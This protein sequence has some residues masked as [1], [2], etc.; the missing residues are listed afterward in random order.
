MYWR[1]GIHTIELSV[2]FSASL[3]ALLAAGVLIS[4]VTT[5]M[6][7]RLLEPMDFGGDSFDHLNYIR[8]IKANN[9]RIPKRPTHVST[10][11][12]YQYPY[13]LHWL[14]SFAP[15]RTLLYFER[16]SSAFF[17]ILLCMLIFSTVPMGYLSSLEAVFAA[18]ALLTTPQFVIPNY[19]HTTGLSARKFG[20]VLTSTSVMS[21]IYW[22]NSSEVAF[23]IL[24]VLVGAG[25]FLSSKFSVQAYVPFMLILIVLSPLSG[26]TTLAGS[27]GLAIV[28]SKGRYL[29]IAH[30]HY[31]HLRNYALN[32]QFKVPYTKPRSPIAE[33]RG[34][35]ETVTSS[36][37]VV[38]AVKEMHNSRILGSLMRNPHTVISLTLVLSTHPVTGRLPQIFQ[39]WLIGGFILFLL[40]SLPYLRFLGQEDRYLEYVI[41]PAGAV[42]GKFAVMTLPTGVVYGATALFGGAIIVY[43]IINYWTT[44]QNIRDMEKIINELKERDGDVVLAQPRWIAQRIAW[45]AEIEVVDITLN[46]GSSKKVIDEINNLCPADSFHITD[47][48]QWLDETFHPDWV[49]FY[50]QT[51]RPD[52]SLDPQNADAVFEDGEFSLY[53]FCDIKEEY[54]LSSDKNSCS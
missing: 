15:K 54:S 41:I 25:V 53:R 48:V 14:L 8:D 6:A 37:S 52:G 40:T 46:A 44:G 18:G 10:S 26:L 31:T 28:A 35:V 32:G 27:V 19:S 21:L 30:S 13:L 39:Y 4:V 43:Y 1:I 42:M 3:T 47:D 22:R 50:Q 17:D 11:G 23:L 51:D 45:K 9:H 7:Y 16:Y 38:D 49:V 34:F 5:R 20:L 2:M 24:A 29:D 36:A 12:Y 33:F